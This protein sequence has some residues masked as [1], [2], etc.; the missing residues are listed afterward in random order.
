M[1]SLKKIDIL[2]NNNENLDFY[3]LNDFNN[4]LNF[5]LKEIFVYADLIN[6]NRFLIK[7]KLEILVNHFL[8]RKKQPKTTVLLEEKALNDMLI[9]I[10]IS[11]YNY[12]KKF[13]VAPNFKYIDI[14]KILK[15]EYYEIYK[16]NAK[17]RNAK[18]R[19][20]LKFKVLRK[21]I[22][23]VALF[24]LNCKRKNFEFTKFENFVNTLKFLISEDLQKLYYPQKVFL[25]VGYFAFNNLIVNSF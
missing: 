18:K 11:C 3:Y 19:Y 7:Q 5:H 4:N 25:T 6:K 23:K 14:F 24:N 9:F 21:L 16:K 10:I 20:F 22:K 2:V 15:D 17:K 8:P 13:E 1:F 12:F